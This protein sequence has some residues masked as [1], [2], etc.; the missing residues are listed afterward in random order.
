MYKKI[1]ATL[2]F[3]IANFICFAIDLRDSDI[4][5]IEKVG[6]KNGCVYI[7]NTSTKL[8]KG[9][10]FKATD[11]VYLNDGEYLK[12]RNM[13]TKKNIVVCAEHF[14]FKDLP[15]GS[16][17]IRLKM[18]GTKSGDDF[19]EY[20]SES[21]WCL[22]EDT[23]RIE[24][25]YKLNNTT[26][27]FILKPIPAMPNKRELYVEYD[28]ETNELLFTTD[29]FKKNGISIE[30]LDSMQ[31]YMEYWNDGNSIPITTDLKFRYIKPL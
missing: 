23:V 28:E 31:F 27:G 9:S 17:F 8:T 13:R 3:C 7:G 1:I 21:P 22:I 2:L 19:T 12:T 18:A 11:K 6:T 29:Y 4:L 16:S 30:R 14:K 24:C 25:Y 10:R 15:S 5:V 26:C 20:I